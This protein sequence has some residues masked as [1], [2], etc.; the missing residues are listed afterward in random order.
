MRPKTT[1]AASGPSPIRTTRSSAHSNATGAAATRGVTAFGASTNTESP[2]TLTSVM[3]A[4]TVLFKNTAELHRPRRQDGISYRYGL[5]GTPTTYTL[6][7]R[8]AQHLTRSCDVDYISFAQGSHSRSLERHI[9]DAYGPR[10][11]YV[12]L[13]AHT[14]ANFVGSTDAFWLTSPKIGRAHV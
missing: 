7:A 11:P 6:A 9:P 2:T 5:P 10:A 1:L 4:S 12:P 13:I 14:P 3:K 8:I